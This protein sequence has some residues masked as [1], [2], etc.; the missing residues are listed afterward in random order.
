MIFKNQTPDTARIDIFCVVPNETLNFLNFDGAYNATYKIN[1]TITDST[2]KTII[3][4][5][6]EKTITT[7]DFLATQGANAEFSQ[8]QIQCFL[9]SGNYKIRLVLTDVFSNVEYEKSRTISVIIFLIMIF[10]ISGI[11][12]S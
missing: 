10:S 9:N 6:I 4:K 7:E 12:I 5:K 11:F 2:N 3:S 8:V 1:L